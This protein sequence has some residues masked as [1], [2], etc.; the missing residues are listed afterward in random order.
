MSKPSEH[1]ASSAPDAER[2]YTSQSIPQ[3]N[4]SSGNGE[5]MQWPEW[6][7]R[8]L[9][10]SIPAWAIALGAVVLLLIALD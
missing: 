1:T 2:P 10:L 3:P 6:L 5:A 9:Q 7:N 8:R 4:P